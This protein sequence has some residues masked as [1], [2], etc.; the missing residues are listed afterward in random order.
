MQII[1][2]SRVATKMGID[3]PKEPAGEK[4]SHPRLENGRE[5]VVLFIF[6]TSILFD[7][8]SVYN[9]SNKNCKTEHYVFYLEADEKRIL[10]QLINADIKSAMDNKN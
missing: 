8:I 2:G 3:T 7:V 4:R 10:L 9:S 1:T 6:F 5:A